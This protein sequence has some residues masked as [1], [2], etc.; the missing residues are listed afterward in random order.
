[1]KAEKNRFVDSESDERKTH[2]NLTGGS[3][4]FPASKV[5][6]SENQ[7]KGNIHAQVQGRNSGGVRA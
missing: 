7:R 2:E 4:H 6:P 5:A 3:G 1:M